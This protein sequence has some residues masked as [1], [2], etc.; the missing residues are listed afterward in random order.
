MAQPGPGQFRRLYRVPR[1][2]GGIL[3]GLCAGIGKHLNTDPVL[4]RM[5]FIL[6]VLLVPAGLAAL[7]VYLLFGLVV[8]VEQP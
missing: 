2:H 1:G 6:L 8:P 7:L 4:I 3:L 5:V